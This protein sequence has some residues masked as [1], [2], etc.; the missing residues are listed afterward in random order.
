MQKPISNRKDTKNNPEP[1]NEEAMAQQKIIQNSTTEA[2]TKF[3]ETWL[4][5]VIKVR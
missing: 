2:R 5:K 1:G 4:W 3:P